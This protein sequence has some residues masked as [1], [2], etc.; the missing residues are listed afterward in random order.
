L[1]DHA[2][3]KKLNRINGACYSNSVAILAGAGRPEIVDFHGLSGVGMV[4]APHP[5]TRVRCAGARAG[6]PA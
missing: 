6:L 1:A 2:A 4:L 3:L 5:I